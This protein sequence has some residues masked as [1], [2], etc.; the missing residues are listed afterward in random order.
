MSVVVIRLAPLCGLDPSQSDRVQKRQNSFSAD[1][2]VTTE[3]IKH[4]LLSLCESVCVYVKVVFEVYV[5]TC[6]F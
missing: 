5:L 4:K 2:S 6:I 1:R 3:L